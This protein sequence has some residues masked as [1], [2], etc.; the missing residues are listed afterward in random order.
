PS[1][2][3]PRPQWACGRTTRRQP[4]V[5]AK[6]VSS[7]TSP[8]SRWRR[9]ACWSASQWTPCGQL[10]YE[11]RPFYKADRRTWYV[12]VGRFQPKLGK[13]PD[14]LLAPKKGKDG[15][16]QAPPEIVADFRCISS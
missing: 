5:G 2:R 15:I 3:L 14:N 6:A 16:W 12:E 13:H 8:A 4:P 10:R 9:T 11:P 7:R 1:Q